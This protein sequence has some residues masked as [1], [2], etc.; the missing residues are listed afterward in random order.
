MSDFTSDTLMIFGD[1]RGKRLADVPKEYLK[2][3]YDT[4]LWKST[5]GNYRR[6]KEYCE[7]NAIQLK[8]TIV[9]PRE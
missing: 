5:Y 9:K 6:L 8:I 7:K 2:W 3:A 4:I 1:H